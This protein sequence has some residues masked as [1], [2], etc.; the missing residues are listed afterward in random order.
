MRNTKNRNNC[1]AYRCAI[2]GLAAILGCLLLAAALVAQTTGSGVIQ[3]TVTD[4]TGAVIAA[5]KVTVE[6]IAT[7]QKRTTTT[8]QVGF[9]LFPA[10]LPGDY[11]LSAEAGGMQTWQGKLTLPVGQT[12]VVDIAMSLGSTLSQVTVAGDVTPLLTLNS[13][14]LANTLERTRIEELPLN[15]RFLQNLVASTIPGVEGNANAPKVNGLSRGATEF[16][17]DGVNLANRDEDTHIGSRPPGV[18]TVQEF[19]VESSNSSAKMSR[20]VEIIIST[21][22]GTNQ[23]H[24]SLFETARNNGLGVARRREEYWSKAPHLVRNEFGASGGGPVRIPHV[25]NGTNRTFFFFAFEGYRNAQASSFS[26]NLPTAAMRQGDWS[27]LTDTAGRPVTLYD[28]WTTDSVTWQRQPFL[29]NVIPLMR[30]GPAAKY[31]YSVTPLPTMP[32]MNPIIQ[33]NYTGFAAFTQRE[34]TETLRVDHRLSE[35]DQIFVRYTFGKTYQPDLLSGAMPPTT[36]GKTGLGYRL[37][38]TQN[39]VLSWM[40]TFSPTFF[41]ETLVLRP[42][43]DCRTSP[44]SQRELGQNWFADPLALPACRK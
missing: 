41:S 29:G 1:T 22:S 16:L 6:N 8:N 38:T 43:E 39:A 19:R 17:Q 5:T 3:G 4:P 36:D 9:Y 24:G 10:L 13:A 40:H 25:Y 2:R 42:E 35:H 28:P 37:A 23:F 33:N 21:R 7:A 44:A 34:H 15:G 31:L 14:T 27:K 20:P 30:E 18:D 26:T 11:T 32:D 12:A